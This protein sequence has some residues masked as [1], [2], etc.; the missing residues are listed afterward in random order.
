MFLYG[1]ARNVDYNIRIDYNRVFHLN[2]NRISI[3][4]TKQQLDKLPLH[5]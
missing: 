5:S 4:L 3:F 1:E 2:E